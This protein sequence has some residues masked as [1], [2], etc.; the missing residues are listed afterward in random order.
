[1]GLTSDLKY[2]FNWEPK[3]LSDFF[4][5]CFLMLLLSW[6]CTIFFARHFLVLPIFLCVNLIHFIPD[7]S[8]LLHPIAF[9]MVYC[10]YFRLHQTLQRTT[11]WDVFSCM[12]LLSE[13]LVINKWSPSPN[14]SWWGGRWC[15]SWQ[16]SWL[17]AWVC[18][19][20]TLAWL[21]AY[22]TLPTVFRA[23]GWTGGLFLL[24]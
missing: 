10:D 19:S 8:F 4:C 14:Q 6:N 15:R 2:W 16:Q 17:W 3:K 20:Q 7:W 24:R 21:W 1:M 13:Y 12:N 18:Q 5:Q 23:L 11:F 22:L 9:W